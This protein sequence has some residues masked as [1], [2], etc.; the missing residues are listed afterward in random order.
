[1]I[2]IFQYGCIVS[3]CSDGSVKVWSH[4]GTEITTLYGH[5]Q[6][7]NSCDL[8]VRV[9]QGQEVK[10]KR[11]LFV[12]MLYIV[13]KSGI[14]KQHTC[15]FLSK[16]ASC[17]CQYCWSFVLKH[18]V[19]CHGYILLLKQGSRNSSLN[20]NKVICTCWCFWSHVLKHFV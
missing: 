11:I 15:S 12:A 7:A 5:T 20:E 13:T 16:N 14:Q 1:M 3:S 2:I 8:L 6:R 17:T 9:S 19:C 4:K 18:F 10:G